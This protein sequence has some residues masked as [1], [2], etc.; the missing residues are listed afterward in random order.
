MYIPANEG[1]ALINAPGRNSNYWVN[2]H[3]TGQVAPV[4]LT[5]LHYQ[6]FYYRLLIPTT[7]TPGSYIPRRLLISLLIR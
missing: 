4:W 6:G 1:A 7:D 5:Y 3:V 2:G